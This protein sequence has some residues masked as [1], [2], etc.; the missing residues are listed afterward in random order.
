M[1]PERDTP[2]QAPKNLAFSLDDSFMTQGSLA[3]GVFFEQTV[4]DNLLKEW[5]GF[6]SSLNG[7]LEEI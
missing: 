6:N 3:R 1:E 4:R 2:Q 5:I 7:T